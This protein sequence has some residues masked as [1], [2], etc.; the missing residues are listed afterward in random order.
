MQLFLRGRDEARSP[1]GIQERKRK[2][3]AETL[4]AQRLAEKRGRKIAQ[5]KERP[6]FR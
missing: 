6:R 3:N 4:R 5:S 2:D 1:R